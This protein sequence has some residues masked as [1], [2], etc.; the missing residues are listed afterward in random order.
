MSTFW[1]RRA[2]SAMPV[3]FGVTLVTF[4][5]AHTAGGSIVPGLPFNPDLTPADVEQIRNNLG[6]DRPLPVQYLSW[7]WDLLHLDFGRSML[8]RR[9]VLG[10]IVER[11]PNTL[12]LTGTA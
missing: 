5:I 7:L 1:G 6:L 9:P 4:L 8:D 10:L 12:F 3:L 2:L 11:L